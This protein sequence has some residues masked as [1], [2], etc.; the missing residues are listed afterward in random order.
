MPGAKPGANPRDREEFERRSI[1]VFIEQQMTNRQQTIELQLAAESRQSIQMTCDIQEFMTLFPRL[2]ATLIQETYLQHAGERQ[3][4]IDEL[5][6][7]GDGE[8][9]MQPT[10]SLNMD[11]DFPSLGRSTGDQHVQA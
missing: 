6:L 8:P 7:I 3:A 4:V 11:A 10:H 9:S 2:D 1:A 5:L